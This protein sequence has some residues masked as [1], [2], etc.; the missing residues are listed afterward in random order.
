MAVII[1][2]ARACILPA[3][4]N[5]AVLAPIEHKGLP[6]G[7]AGRKASHAYY[8]N[9]D[10]AKKRRAEPGSTS[11]CP[12]ILTGDQLVINSQCRKNAP[13]TVISREVAHWT[14]SIQIASQL[15]HKNLK[16]GKAPNRKSAARQPCLTALWRQSG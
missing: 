5:V 6:L 9:G 13:E 8:F 16:T 1:F 7:L 3:F 2:E 4:F 11:P 14:C 10:S 15:K 12:C